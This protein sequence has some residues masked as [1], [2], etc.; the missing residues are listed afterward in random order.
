MESTEFDKNTEPKI[1]PVKLPLHEVLLANGYEIDREKSTARNP[2]LKSSGGHKVIISLMPSG[3]YLYFNPNDDR[4]K[5][6]IYTL[7]KN[8]GLDINEMIESYL[9]MPVNKQ[10]N[11]KAKSEKENVKEFVDK[12]T[13]ISLV[14][15]YH[16]SL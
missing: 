15:L 10:F 4:D 5:G 6:N 1:A 14:N 7:A 2:V 16:K 11:I 8:H 9:Q 12:F 3:D 13:K